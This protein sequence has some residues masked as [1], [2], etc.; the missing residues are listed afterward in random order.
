MS[1]RYPNLLNLRLTDED[2]IQLDQMSKKLDTPR[3]TLVRRGWREWMLTNGGDSI[4]TRGIPSS[5]ATCDRSSSNQ[6]ENW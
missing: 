1:I 2:L 5:A 6:K 3:S 4:A